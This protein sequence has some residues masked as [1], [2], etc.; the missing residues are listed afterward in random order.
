MAGFRT[1]VVYCARLSFY[2]L[3]DR[4]N[5]SFDWVEYL[6]TPISAAGVATLQS[7][8]PCGSSYKKTVPTVVSNCPPSTCSDTSWF[9]GTGQNGS[10]S[11]E[12]NGLPIYGNVELNSA[13][14]ASVTSL[15]LSEQ[16]SQPDIGFNTPVTGINVLIFVNAKPCSASTTTSSF[17]GLFSEGACIPTFIGE[18]WVG[19]RETFGYEGPSPGVS[20]SGI[21]NRTRTIYATTDCKA[22]ED[23]TI[24]FFEKGTMAFP[25]VSSGTPGAFQVT[26][27]PLYTLITPGPGDD[28]GAADM[29]TKYCLCGHS[30]WI[31]DLQRRITTCP[32]ASCKAFAWYD[33][34]PFG[35]EVYA[36]AEHVEMAGET[37]E[38]RFSAFSTS[39]E[40][41]WSATP[42]D[43]AFAIPKK[44]SCSAGAFS[45]NFCG[46]YQ[47]ECATS[48]A[49]NMD[50]KISYLLGGGVGADK[51]DYRDGTFLMV[52]TLYAPSTDCDDDSF[53]LNITAQGYYSIQ[54]NGSAAAPDGVFNVIVKFRSLSV[55]PQ[56]QASVTDLNDPD[57]GC[58]CGG[59]WTLGIT[60]VLYQCPH[61]SCPG[62]TQYFIGSDYGALGT[63]GYGNVVLDGRTFRMTQLQAGPTD[64]FNQVCL[65]DRFDSAD[66]IA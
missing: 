60:R 5:I 12:M 4:R 44:E 24:S 17:C 40:T 11:I 18:D 28:G 21:Y 38:I 51:I 27:H 16:S 34:L 37:S 46:L 49:V 8:C 14:P 56:N 35:S 52:R 33:G 15:T 61:Q 23:V 2:D 30:S 50:E 54:G 26:R 6:V 3:F 58:P 19:L 32:V 65:W 7:A 47:L 20:T 66:F 57:G 9:G 42:E 64:G 1:N 63:A 41:G 29:L 45:A 25:D 13:N 55:T 22:E 39:S 53:E 43:G 48:T 10:D 31:T 36:A 62:G 59:K